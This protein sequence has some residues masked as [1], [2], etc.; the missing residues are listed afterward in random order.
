MYNQQR[1]SNATLRRGV[2]GFNCARQGIQS[3]RHVCQ[4]GRTVS[5]TSTPLIRNLLYPRYDPPTLYT[6]TLTCSIPSTSALNPLPHIF[7]VASS[8][9]PALPQSLSFR[10][11]NP[12]ESP[13]S[14][15]FLAS[16][17]LVGGGQKD[18]LAEASAVLIAQLGKMRITGQ[19]WEDKVAFLEF[20]RGKTG[21]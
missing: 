19:A 20:Y 4:V 7:Q 17:V 6:P 14:G 5:P 16:D 21:K 1:S 13:S 8:L 15:S 10:L 11:L 9:S 12:A 3:L 18:E 2:R